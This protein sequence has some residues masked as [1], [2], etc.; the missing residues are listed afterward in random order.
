MKLVMVKY[1]AGNVKAVEI[2]LNKLGI[3]P[4]ISNNPDD[5]LSA[6]RIIFPGVGNAAAAWED[7]KRTRLDKLIPTL[8]QP[9]LGVCLGMQ[10]LCSHSEEGD[11]PGL[12]IVPLEVKRF[13]NGLKV[14]HIGWNNVYASGTELFEDIDENEYFYFVHSYFVEKGKA[15]I[16]TCDYGYPFSAAIHAGNFWGIQ[17]HPEISALAGSCILSNFLNMQP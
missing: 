15:T 4:L 5:L 10:F 7:L 6:D 13:D 14:P 11:T 12:N 16:A 1:N 8:K 9:V 2:A 3:S 17:F